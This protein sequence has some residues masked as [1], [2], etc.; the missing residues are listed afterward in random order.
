MKSDIDDELDLR[1]LL[2]PHWFRIHARWWEGGSAELICETVQILKH[3]PK[4]VRVYGGKLVLRDYVHRGRAYAAPTV[5]QAEE[6][7][8]KRKLWQIGRLKSKLNQAEAELAL[9]A[10]KVNMP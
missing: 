7:F 4:G 1:E 5:E 9:L 6:D 8:R 2:E 10:P 3:T